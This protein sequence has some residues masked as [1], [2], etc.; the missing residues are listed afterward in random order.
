[1]V[2]DCCFVLC[3]VLY[4]LPPPPV[5]RFT[6]WELLFL[7]SSKSVECRVCWVE[8]VSLAY[9]QPPS[10]FSFYVKVLRSPSVFSPEVYLACIL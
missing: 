4:L 9:V 6:L 3:F 1:M 10:S 2:A 8:G 5:S 7:D